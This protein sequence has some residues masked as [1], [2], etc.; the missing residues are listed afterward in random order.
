M[1]RGFPF[2]LLKVVLYTLCFGRAHSKGETSLGE[3][4]KYPKGPWAHGASDTQGR[5]K[6]FSLWSGWP[7]WHS[8]NQRAL[9]LGYR[10]PH[11]QVRLRNSQKGAAPL[12]QNS[13]GTT[14]LWKL[15]ELHTAFPAIATCLG[16]S[17]FTDGSG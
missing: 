1:K 5:A 15:P 10:Q 7:Q 4:C 17:T 13:S 11:R 9:G 3:S 2:L 12:R 6:E 14:C 16:L 8:Q